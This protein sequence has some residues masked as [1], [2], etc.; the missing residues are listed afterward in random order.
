LAT[1]ARNN[2]FLE[3]FRPPKKK[4][5]MRIFPLLDSQLISFLDV[6][7]RDEA[8]DVLVDLLDQSDRLPNKQKFRQAIFDREQL[9]STGIGM[10]VAVPHA[11]LGDF[12]DF[13][14]A[15]GIQQRKGLDWKALDTVPVRLIFMIG[16]PDNKQSEYLRI[17][18]QL[19]SAIRDPELR[20]AL[21]KADSSQEVLNLFS[22]F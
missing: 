11:K 7:T 13:F 4:E 19:T 20:K 17:L 22:Q 9:V 5:H 15:I 3:F 6:T 16:G 8:I 2:S 14:I 12:P 21:L 18:S 1:L 10:G